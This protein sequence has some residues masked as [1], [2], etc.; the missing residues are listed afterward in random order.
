MLFLKDY[1]RDNLNIVD[2][3]IIIITVAELFII[4]D[5]YKIGNSFLIY[6]RFLLTIKVFR[7]LRLIRNIKFMEFIMQVLM[8]SLSSFAYIA[9][10]L[11][12]FTFVYALLG[13]HIFGGNFKKENPLYDIYNFD[14]FLLSF[15]NVFNVMTMDNWNKILILSKESGL[16]SKI[17]N[18]YL[19]SWI[20]FGNFILLN[21]FLAILL[22]SFTSNLDLT[23][24][25]IENEDD[26]IIE[27]RAEMILTNENL[28]NIIMKNKTN[29]V[30]NSPK[31]NKNQR[32]MIVEKLPSVETFNKKTIQMD[33]LKES[34]DTT[35]TMRFERDFEDN[36]ETIFGTHSRKNHAD[37]NDC[38][39]SL[40]LFRIDGKVRIFFKSICEN[41][42][43]DDFFLI[44]V[45]LNCVKLVTDT[46]IFH[47]KVTSFKLFILD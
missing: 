15:I 46:F 17:T 42:Y 5:L 8:R 12:L 22:Y 27:K 33:S 41:K 1:L 18:L 31:K 40:Y 4:D 6:F 16:N 35:F 37:H 7:L 2:L 11:I 3:M 20:F 14:S 32:G 26:E 24:I 38:L 36:E 10:L 30:L 45:F 34:D 39:Y 25:V 28:N 44:I 19:I 13:M 23:D 43:F 9:L 29:S 21:L 47:Q